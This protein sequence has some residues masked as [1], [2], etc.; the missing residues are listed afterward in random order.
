MTRTRPAAAGPR[1]FCLPLFHVLDCA[2]EVEIDGCEQ[3]P[4][5]LELSPSR[6]QIRLANEE[7]LTFEDQDVRVIGGSATFTD[8]DGYPHQVRFSTASALEEDDVA[9]H[10]A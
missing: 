7:D 2:D 10:F 9:P 3:L 6:R 1:G 5:Y 8:V 4:R